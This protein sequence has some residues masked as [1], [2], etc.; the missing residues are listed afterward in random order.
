MTEASVCNDIEPWKKLTPD[1]GRFVARCWARLRRPSKL[2]VALEII[3]IQ[4][5]KPNLASG[6]P[7]PTP[8]QLQ[9]V[10]ILPLPDPPTIT[11]ILT[12]AR[13]LTAA[14]YMW[15]QFSV[16]EDKAKRVSQ[17]CFCIELHNMISAEKEKLREAF[18]EERQ[19]YRRDSIGKWLRIL[20]VFLAIGQLV[21]IQSSKP[22]FD[23]I[24]LRTSYNVAR[25]MLRLEAYGE[26]KE[27][28]ETFNFDW[29]DWRIDVIRDP[30]KPEQIFDPKNARFWN[31][32]TNDD[33]DD[34]NDDDDNDDNDDNDDDD[35]DNDD[36]DAKT[37]VDAFPGGKVEGK[38][39]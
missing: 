9:P 13:L 17:A 25:N 31:S 15:E 5:E 6:R 3:R 21:H 32:I 27:F 22:A 33:D 39:T 4:A 2:T 35:D 18:F 20:R 30:K 11:S 14:S 28:S 34:D 29:D 38:K 1:Q 26:N 37:A 10:R 7:D 36:D 19:E 16:E 8:R 24:L 23:G 12:D